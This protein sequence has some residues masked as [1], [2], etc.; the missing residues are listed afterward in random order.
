MDL[1]EEMPPRAKLEEIIEANK[2]EK[3]V[4][5]SRLS[6]VFGQFDHNQYWWSHSQDSGDLKNLLLRCVQNMLVRTDHQV[7]HP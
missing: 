5:L 6:I 1:V 7:R 4:K 2:L 3:W